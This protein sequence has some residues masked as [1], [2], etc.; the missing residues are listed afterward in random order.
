MIHI[1]KK[2]GDGVERQY[3]VCTVYLRNTSL[4]L[5]WGTPI[6]LEEHQ[7]L[8][9]QIINN[10]ND[11]VLKCCGLVDLA[12]PSNPLFIPCL[13]ASNSSRLVR[14]LNDHFWQRC[15]S[16]RGVSL[17]DGYLWQSCISVR[18]VSLAKVYLW[19]SW[20]TSLLEG[21]QILLT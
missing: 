7:L 19:Q 13:L 21:I 14:R 5:Y 8:L 1:I 12:W 15:I 11:M 20:E 18:G 3:G 10:Q 2:C 16:D 4:C 17:A 9:E 6:L